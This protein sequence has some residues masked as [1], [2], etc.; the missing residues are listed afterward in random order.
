[1]PIEEL[2]INNKDAY[3]EWGIS[4]K[5]TEGLSALMTPSPNKELPENKSR[6]TNGKTVIAGQSIV[7][8]DERDISLPIQL[9]A[10][11]ESAFFTRYAS[12]CNELAE[13]RLDIKTKYQPNVVYHT[14]YISCQQFSQFMCGIASFTLRLN[15]P[16]PA[17]RS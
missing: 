6:L 7:K 8:V 15:E 13:G 2:Y 4:L 11:N 16:N 5:G 1:M 10:P 12:F 3:K 17:N 9:T 14:D